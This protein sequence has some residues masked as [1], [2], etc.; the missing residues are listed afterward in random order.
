MTWNQIVIVIGILVLAMLAIG[1][2]LVLDRTRKYRATDE[3]T[4]VVRA[5]AAVL[6]VVGLLILCVI[7]LGSNF[8]AQLRATLVGGLVT[9]VGSAVTFYFTSREAAQNRKA[10]QRSDA[11]T[12]AVPDVKGKTRE[13]AKAMLE[14]HNLRMEVAPG[15][16]DNPALSVAYEHPRGGESA[17]KGSS[18]LVTLEQPLR[19]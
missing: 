6:L 17:L 19:R 8:D 13:Q 14:K 11:D 10:W 12:T 1:G 3:D 4:S 2:L 9:S 15:A 7:A 18:V 16:P 5:W